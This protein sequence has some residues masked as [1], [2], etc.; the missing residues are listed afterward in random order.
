MAQTN[1]LEPPMDAT[2]EVEVI[3]FDF[4]MVL[5]PGETILSVSQMLCGISSGIDPA[6]SSRLIG[7]PQIGASPTTG[8]LASAVLQKVGNVLADCCYALQCVAHTSDDQELSL[9][10]QLPTETSVA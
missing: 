5:K 9:Q 8:A 10:A 2:Y 4:G 1:A 3:A 7:S 6:P